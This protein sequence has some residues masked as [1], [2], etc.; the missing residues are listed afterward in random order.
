MDFGGLFSG[1]S[2]IVVVVEL[3]FCNFNSVKEVENGSS[4]EGKTGSQEEAG[5]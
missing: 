4:E 3:Y 2:G 1:A 5:S